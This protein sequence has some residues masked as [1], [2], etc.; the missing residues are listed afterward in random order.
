MAI[1]NKYNFNMKVHE[2]IT[3]AAS[4]A[5]DK[6]LNGEQL[7]TYTKDLNLLLRSLASKGRPLALVE[8]QAITTSVGQMDYDLSAN[9]QDINEITV[10]SSVSTAAE[11]QMTRYSLAEFLRIPTKTTTG[12][13]TVYATERHYDGVNLRLWPKPDKQYTV[14]MYVF[15]KPSD[16]FKYTDTLK[17]DQNYLPAII[18]GLAYHIGIE[19]E[20]PLEKLALLK[21]Q[22]DEELMVVHKDDRERAAY[23][24]VP[25]RR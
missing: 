21:Q 10:K 7:R 13:P 15:T 12:R 14:N 11:L 2:I 8:R 25:G 23:R 17:L 16:A 5:I 18:F 22:Y 1:S 6:N 4:K 20:I 19:Q 9:V 3:H 24:I